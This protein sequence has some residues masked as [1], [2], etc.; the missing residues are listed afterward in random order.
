MTIH[1]F[2]SG[3]PYKQATACIPFI[4]KAQPADQTAIL[5]LVRSERLNPTRL[6]AKNFHVAEA[7]GRL[8]GAVQLRPHKDGARELG[9]LV[10]T[11]E[12]RG[13]RVA[14]ALI[15]ALL[16]GC[17]EPVHMITDGRFAPHYERWG[18]AP[19]PAGMLPR[20]IRFNYRMGRLARAMSWYRGLPPKRLVVLKRTA[21]KNELARFSET[22]TSSQTST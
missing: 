22:L 9:S 20:S 3:K 10:V 19:V 1:S 2:I 7:E 8:I 18:F 14:A 5:D 16:A 17:D 6:Y 13:M 15:E 11:Q 21:A 12:W 4:R